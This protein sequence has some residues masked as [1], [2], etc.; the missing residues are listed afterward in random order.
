M[1]CS[2]L[3]SLSFSRLRCLDQ[4]VF[5][6]QILQ[7]REFAGEDGYISNSERL[8][9]EA[10]FTGADVRSFLLVVFDVERYLF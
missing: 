7:S 8:A 9:I 10:R 5:F 4:C 3:L 1:F 2:R 6:Y